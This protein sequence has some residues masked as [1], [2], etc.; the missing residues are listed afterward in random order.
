MFGAG[1][2]HRLVLALGYGMLLVYLYFGR[3]AGL[4]HFLVLAL[5]SPQASKGGRGGIVVF[6]FSRATS[7]YAL[8]EVD[9]PKIAT[10]T[11]ATVTAADAAN[12]A[13]APPEDGPSED[14]GD[15]RG[16]LRHATQRHATLRGS[17]SST[18]Q[19]V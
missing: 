9:P 16:S 8:Q 17:Q 2:P 13:T 10:G 7:S 6:A 4:P 12:A 18:A 3:G 19:G 11:A 14:G 15:S 1:L 5:G